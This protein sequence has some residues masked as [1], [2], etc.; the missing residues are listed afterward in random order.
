[1]KT[2]LEIEGVEVFRESIRLDQDFGFQ[3]GQCVKYLS[4]YRW[5]NKPLEDLRKCQFY[6]ARLISDAEGEK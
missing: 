1:M 3:A 2:P 5:K 6:L 4:R